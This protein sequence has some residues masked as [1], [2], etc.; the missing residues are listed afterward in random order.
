MRGREKEKEID[1]ENVR[2]P[3]PRLWVQVLPRSG[4][5]GQ[6]EIVIEREKERGRESSRH[7]STQENA[8]ASTKEA[9][10]CTGTRTGNVTGTC[11]R[12]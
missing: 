2:R 11:P 1:S 10:S 5:G 3:H 6:I 7:E 8:I 4:I 9:G 12:L